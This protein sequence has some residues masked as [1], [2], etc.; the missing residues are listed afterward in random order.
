MEAAREIN[1]HS[2]TASVFPCVG[3]VIFPRQVHNSTADALGQFKSC[4]GVATATAQY[5]ANKVVVR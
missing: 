3:R 5:G 4:G 2:E 1:V